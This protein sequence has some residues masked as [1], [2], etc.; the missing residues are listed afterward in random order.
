MNRT[1]HQRDNP[2]IKLLIELLQQFD[3]LLDDSRLCCI[4][5]GFAAGEDD[6]INCDEVET[7]GA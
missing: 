3:P 4:T 6:G 7:I 1:C 2:D 5:T